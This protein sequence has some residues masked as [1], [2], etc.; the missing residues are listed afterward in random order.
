MGHGGAPGTAADDHDLGVGL[1]NGESAKQG[2]GNAAGTGCQQPFPE[3]P[4]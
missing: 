3:L 1:R 2:R 4:S